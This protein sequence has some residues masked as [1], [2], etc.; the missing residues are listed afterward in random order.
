[1]THA[2]A[3]AIRTQEGPRATYDATLEY[4]KENPICE[5]VHETLLGAAQAAPA[6][7]HAKMGWAKIALQNAFHRL[8]H[9]PDFQE[10]LVATVMAGGDTD[11][12]GCIAGALL[13]AVHGEQG[14]PARW[15][16]T[17]LSCE[18]ERGEVYQ[19]GDAR[20]LAVKLLEAGA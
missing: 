11:T 3:F 16:T 6:D 4:A 14:I 10:G 20:E 7:F 1:M 12:N 19:T 18:T 17:A 13:G 5:P 15:R 9:A 8:L 2:I